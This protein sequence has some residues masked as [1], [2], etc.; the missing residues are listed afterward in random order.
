MT[1]TLITALTISFSYAILVFI[2]FASLRKAKQ[3]LS[4]GGNVTFR[5]IYSLIWVSISGLFSVVLLVSA[6]SIPDQYNALYYSLEDIDKK[7][8]NE[9]QN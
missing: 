8:E 7:I 9:N 2:A 5:L 4:D 3:A 6:T 1:N